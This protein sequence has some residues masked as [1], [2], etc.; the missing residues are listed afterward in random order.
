[1]QVNKAT[2]EVEAE[3]GGKPYRFHATLPRMAAF[4]AAMGVDGIAALLGLVQQSDS[5]A[6]YHGLRT[7]CS[8]GDP[9]EFD[10][11]VMSRVMTDACEAI[12][13]AMVAALPEPDLGNAEAAKATT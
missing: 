12:V 3:I 6:V 4:Q 10:R 5:R 1:M 2:G 7:L 8:N 13:S 9:R 11:L